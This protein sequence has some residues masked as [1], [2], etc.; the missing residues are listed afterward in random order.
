MKRFLAVISF[1]LVTYSIY[2]QENSSWQ[3]YSSVDGVEIYTMETDCYAQNIPDQK[4]IL[5]K[6][7]NTSSEDV[8]VEWDLLVW[9]NGEL[10]KRDVSDKEN[11][12]TVEVRANST[13]I[14]SC[15]V[16]RGA[17]YIYKDFITYETD[18][19]LTDFEL[20]NIQVT[21]N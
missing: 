21:S 17:L 5:I 15:D 16:P 14:G 8:R 2:G 20:K 19:K 6:V 10:V 7:V 1:M 18:T 4:A 9:Y 3:L 12:F 13:E 11:H